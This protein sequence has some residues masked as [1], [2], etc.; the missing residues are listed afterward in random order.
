MLGSWSGGDDWKRLGVVWS[1]RQQ[2]AHQNQN[3]VVYFGESV[4]S[5]R[6][7]DIYYYMWLN[8]TYVGHGTLCFF[9]HLNTTEFFLIRFTASGFK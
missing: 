2:S 6:G 1:L 4:I 7:P 8:S 5:V 3:A 9:S